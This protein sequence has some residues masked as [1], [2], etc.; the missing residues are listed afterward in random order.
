MGKI[1]RGKGVR[2]FIDDKE[3]NIHLPP[4]YKHRNSLLEYAGHLA[5]RMIRR[6]KL[7]RRKP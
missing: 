7:K 5:K 4:D 3:V 6:F 1:I 2:L